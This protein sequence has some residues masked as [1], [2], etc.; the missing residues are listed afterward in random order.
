M[1]NLSQETKERIAGDS[2]LRHANIS[3]SASPSLARLLCSLDPWRSLSLPLSFY[4]VNHF[5]RLDLFLLSLS[6]FPSSL[7]SFF[8]SVLFSFS[9]FS[10]Y[11]LSLISFLVSHTQQLVRSDSLHLSLPFFLSVFLLFPFK[12]F[13]S[14]FFSRTHSLT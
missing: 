12:I 13:F 3:L 2:L 11:Y 7:H 14:L 6:F 10:Y 9:P 8:P 1:L 5:V 4:S